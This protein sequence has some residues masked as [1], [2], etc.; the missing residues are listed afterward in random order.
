M[1]RPTTVRAA[2]G[3]P[4]LRTV[5]RT[6]ADGRV[7]VKWEVRIKKHGRLVTDGTYSTE[8]VARDS[9]KKAT[10]RIESG[11]H[12]SARAGATPFLEVAEQWLAHGKWKPRTAE[13]NKA[14]VN[15]WLKPLHSLPVGHV[16]YDDV[17]VLMTGLRDA[18]LAPATQRRIESVLRAVYADAIKRDLVGV[19]PC[20][21]VDKVKVGKP[22]IVIPETAQVEQLIVKVDEMRAAAIEK[23]F[24][25]GRKN[26]AAESCPWGL[27]VEFAAYTGLR[28]GEIAGLRV[29]HVDFA[30]NSVTVEETVIDLH[31][32]LSVGT[33][34]SDESYRTV[35]DCDPGL[36]TRL[37]DHV[38]DKKPGEYVF[39]AVGEDGTHLP[40]HHSNFNSRVFTPAVK[41]LGLDGMQFKSLRHYYASMLIDE[42]VRVPEV[43]ARL[44]H[45]D[46]AFTLRTYVHLF[47]KP[48]SGLGERLAARRANSRKPQEQ[49]NVRHLRVVGS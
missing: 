31:G 20:R 34:K 44:G 29:R 42:G 21:K 1:P 36:F 27:L 26:S 17:K 48:E 49:S 14:I 40:Y 11:N 28:A 38:T 5:T 24:T 9:L 45:H 3:T 16:R 15:N 7:T 39:G 12:V 10:A 13:T 25:Q 18:G 46:S 23:A 41:A 19:D 47:N 22:K 30:T 4:G 37:K 6:Y 2:T 35:S 33:P 32:K 43:A 8:K